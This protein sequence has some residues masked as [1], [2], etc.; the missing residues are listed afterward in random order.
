[1]YITVNNCE[2]REMYWYVLFVRTGREERVQKLLKRSLDN[3][4]FLPFVPLQESIFKKAGILS[5]ELKQL[6][7]GYVFIESEVS[8]HEFVKTTNQLI[9]SL[10]DIICLVKYSS[11]EISLRESER[12][13]LMSLSNDDHCIES[14]SG[15]IEGDKIRITE[16]PLKGRESIIRK[17]NRHKRQAWIEIEFMGDTRMVNVALEI[18][19][20]VCG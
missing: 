3:D 6:F 12:L 2:V 9:R 4:L 19:E 11:T 14:S 15:I 7:P 5:K 10:L 8:N 1:M 20:K 18:V 16:G 13:M 17:V